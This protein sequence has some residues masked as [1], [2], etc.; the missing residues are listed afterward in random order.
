MEKFKM[1]KFT[2][3]K[4]L[5]DSNILSDSKKLEFIGYKVTQEE[6]TNSSLLMVKDNVYIVTHDNRVRIEDQ[7]SLFDDLEDITVEN[8]ELSNL[9]VNVSF[10]KYS[11]FSIESSFKLVNTHI[12]I[13]GASNIILHDFIHLTRNFNTKLNLILFED[14]NLECYKINIMQIFHANA[15]YVE[16]LILK[17]INIYSSCDDFKF[18]RHITKVKNLEIDNVKFEKRLDLSMS[19]LVHWIGDIDEVT[20]KNM[21]EVNA[22]LL[23][24]VELIGNIRMASVERLNAPLFI[25]C[26]IDYLYAPKLRVSTI[27]DN[28][29]NKRV[30]INKL[31]AILDIHPDEVNRIARINNIGIGCVIDTSNNDKTHMI[32]SVMVNPNY[33]KSKVNNWKELRAQLRR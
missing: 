26:R 9:D 6:N 14:I 10:Y 19:C 24:Q 7:N 18:I 23:Y 5:T 11:L 1:G 33:D 16:N 12:K 29:K 27:L 25:R 28:L 32:G 21:K 31:Q 20:V 22:T 13:E 4:V 30:S 8:M 3:L 17:N 15:I 2:S